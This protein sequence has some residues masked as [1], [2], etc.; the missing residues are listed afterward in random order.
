MPKNYVKILLTRKFSI[1]FAFERKKR[2]NKLNTHMIQEEKVNIFF[3]IRMF[4]YA[5]IKVF[6]IHTNRK[7][8]KIFKRKVEIINNVQVDIQNMLRTNWK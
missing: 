1:Y 7:K 4:I 6:I 5:C 2:K 3:E 8:M